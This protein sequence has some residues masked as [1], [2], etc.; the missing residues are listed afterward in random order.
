M[1]EID[2]S[3]KEGGGALLRVSTAFSAVNGK[4]FHIKSI[5]AG[6]PKPGLMMQHLHA[7]RSI[8]KLSN[9]QVEGLEIGSTHLKF[10][11][12]S[13]KSG[14]FEV[15]VQTAGSISL[16]LQ[17]FIIPAIFAPQEVE[18]TIR[19]GTD[20]RWAPAVDYLCNVTI[21]I[22]KSMGVFIDLELLQRGFYPRGGGLLNAKIKPVEKLKPLNL[23]DLEFDTLK[24]ISYSNKLPNHVTVRQAESAKKLLQN[25]GYEVEIEI[26]SSGDSWG[27]GSGLVLWS[28]FKGRN[29]P[30]VGSSSLGE[31]GKRAEIVG[32]EAANDLLSFLS[33]GAPLDKYMGDQIIPYMAIAGLSS[34]KISEL[35]NH[36][37]TNIYAAGKFTD[38]EFQVKGDLGAVAEITVE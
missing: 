27:P 14:K 19:G 31:P 37:L 16:I 13:L 6:R 24:G 21:P 36:T 12:G 25:A 2:G 22:L 7:A 3:Y 26:D 10:K 5:R 23:H 17:A 8:Q 34:V 28:E 1:I 9:A 32:K 35:T 15:D 20:V 38:N 29:I 33:S 4:P 30:R 18:I 11:P